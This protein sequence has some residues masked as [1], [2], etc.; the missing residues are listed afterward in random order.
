MGRRVEGGSIPPQAKKVEERE[1]E[2]APCPIREPGNTAKFL[3]VFIV[4]AFPVLPAFIHFNVTCR[5]ANNNRT[6]IQDSEDIDA[7]LPT[8]LFLWESY[9]P[10]ITRRR[11]FPCTLRC[12]CILPRRRAL[13]STSTVLAEV[14]LLAQ[15]VGY[16][17]IPSAGDNK[18]SQGS[19]KNIRRTS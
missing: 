19:S 18:N 10:P 5:I 4:R 17:H 1:S 14:A 9:D 8:C 2:S 16:H 13:R 6:S 12:V 11:T 3:R 15:T 7:S